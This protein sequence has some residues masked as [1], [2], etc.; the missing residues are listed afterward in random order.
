M[1][2]CVRK[3]ELC[4]AKKI[5]GFSPFTYFVNSSYNWFL[6]YKTH[7]CLRILITRSHESYLVPYNSDNT[8]PLFLREKKD[9]C[10]FYYQYRN[11]AEWKVTEWN[12]SRMLNF[13]L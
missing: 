9:H 8:G 1:Y 5:Q 2:F 10:E 11:F 3:I 13:T 7:F 6:L 12:M 4:Y